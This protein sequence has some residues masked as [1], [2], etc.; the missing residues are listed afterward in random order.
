VTVQ[1][2]NFDV[3]AMFLKYF[4]GFDDVGIGQRID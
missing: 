3:S 4:F 1:T 2:A